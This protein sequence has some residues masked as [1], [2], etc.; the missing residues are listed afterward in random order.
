MAEEGVQGARPGFVCDGRG[1]ALEAVFIPSHLIVSLVYA[2]AL[3]QEA[4]LE[5]DRFEDEVS[6]S[7]VGALAHRALRSGR[8]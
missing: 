5:K 2:A 1:G 8:A 7:C 3:E 6:D 4:K